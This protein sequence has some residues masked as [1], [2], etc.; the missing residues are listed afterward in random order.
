MNK[1]HSAVLAA[2]G[3]NLKHGSSSFTKTLRYKT[4]VHA[5]G[6]LLIGAAYTDRL[7]LEGGTIMDIEP[8]PDGTGFTVRVSADQEDEETADEEAEVAY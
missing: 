3:I 6:N 4:T 8:L 7:N 5:N 1:F 2:N